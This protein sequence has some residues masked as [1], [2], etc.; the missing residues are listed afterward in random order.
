[1]HSLSGTNN[2]QGDEGASQTSDNAVNNQS[3]QTGCCCKA[4]EA[5]AGAA[6]TSYHVPACQSCGITFGGNVP[7]VRHTE[8]GSLW[9]CTSGYQ[10]RHTAPPLGPV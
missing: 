1:M 3:Q 9:F 4:V 10:R 6:P 8:H 5:L 2:Q 7:P